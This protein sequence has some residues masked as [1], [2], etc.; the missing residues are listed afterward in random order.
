MVDLITVGNHAMIG[1]IYKSVQVIG[2]SSDSDAEVSTFIP[3]NP[4][5][6]SVKFK[7]IIQISTP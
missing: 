4:I 2:P 7:K 5:P 6:F 3:P 1:R